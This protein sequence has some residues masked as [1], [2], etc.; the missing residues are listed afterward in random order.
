MADKLPTGMT[1]DSR[2]GILY[3][4]RRIPQP[5][6][7]AFSVGQF[8]KVSLETRDLSEARSRFAI[9][10]GEFEAKCKAFREALAN[11]DQGSLSPEEA[12]GLVTRL[13]MNR[14][15]A[16]VASG[17]LNAAFLLRDLDDLISELEGERRPTAQDMTPEEW[18]EY[19]TRISGGE[20]D[21]ELAPETLARLQERHEQDQRSW[22]DRWLAFQRRVPRRR[23]R[24]LLRQTIEDVKRHL[25]LPAGEMPGIDE[26]LAD[27]IAN[28]LASEAV[29]GQAAVAQPD[30]RR[31]RRTRLRPKMKLDELLAEWV[32]LHKPKPKS[33]AAAEKAVRDFKSYIGDMAV[34]EIGSADCFDFRDA[35]VVMPKSMPRTLRSMSFR[36][37]HA[38]YAARR[39]VARVDPATTKKY[40]GA[41]QALLS[42]AFQEQWIPSNPGAG[43][44]VKGYSK[45]SDRRP[46]TTDEL[47]KLFA[48]P[49]FT[50]PWSE[51][52]SRSKVSD[53][54][55][56]WL[57][58]LAL[59]SGGR[60]EELGQV[61]LADIKQQGGVWYIEVDDYVAPDV[62]ASK[63][64]KTESSKRVLPIHQTLVALGFPARVQSLRGA[65][66][67]RL[68]PDLTKAALDVHTKEASRRAGRIIDAAVGEDPRLVFH[69]LRHSFKDLCRAAR[70]GKETH[71][72]LTGHAPVDVGSHYGSGLA[73]CD[74]ATE[75]AR[76][77]V[78][79]IDW[80][81]MMQA[82]AV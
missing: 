21:R 11:A 1:Q 13:L 75:L 76:I 67:L 58:L 31:T 26:P 77:D 52:H 42:C 51:R 46:F 81:A 15:T 2:S 47:A 63:S 7:P 70:I 27:A 82:A 10:N 9:A 18:R 4:R 59:F 32:T 25:D 60:I 69:S 62:D 16:G 35:L 38:I 78:S 22:G 55:L 34:I 80:E 53:S 43:I 61:L 17:G 56:R 39:D 24:P 73:I 74:L 41:I 64:V 29:R 33:V 49:L 28:A 71:D 65:G 79:F 12:E 66:E 5:L 14:S 36:D 72:Q 37:L 54:T 50:Q 44:K 57:F 19:L 8:Y 3:L 20:D 68:F 30:A 45:R 6:I 23:W 48:A 40:L